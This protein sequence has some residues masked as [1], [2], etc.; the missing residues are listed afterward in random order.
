MKAYEFLKQH[1]PI[2]LQMCRAGV[3]ASDIRHLEL[4]DFV[5]A[6]SK[7]YG[8]SYAVAAAAERYRMSVRNVWAVLQ[9]LDA[10][11]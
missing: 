1:K 8:R 7:P 11:I 2:A 10:E 4:Y 5:E 6:K 3:S 9:R